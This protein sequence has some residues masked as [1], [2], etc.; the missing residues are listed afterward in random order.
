M[1]RYLSLV[2]VMF[3]L[4][5]SIGHAAG[6]EIIQISMNN[7]KIDVTQVPIIMDGKEV[8]TES[9]SFIHENRTLVPIRFVEKNY[10]AEVIWEGETRSVIV[11]YSDYS[12]KLTIDSPIATIYKEK[13][14]KKILDKGS[15]PRLVTFSDN[16]TRTMVPLSF[17]SEVLGFEVG[18]DAENKV[19]YI[20][21]KEKVE[22]D[23]EPE[24][25]V[26]PVDPGTQIKSGIISNIGVYKGSTDK[27]KIILESDKELHY[28]T[29]LI[30]ETLTFVIDVRQAKLSQKNTLDA[31]GLIGVDDDFIKEVRYSQFS[32]KP[33]I[34]RIAIDL[35]EKNIPNIMPRTDGTGLMI[36]FEN[37]SMESITKELIDDKEAIVLNGANG[38][39]MNIMKLRN[40]ERLVIDFLDTV[41]EGEPYASYPYD[42]GFIKGVRVSQF[43]ADNNYSSSD[44][45]VRVVLDIKDGV[46][47][48]NVKI[49]TQEDKVI[50]YPEKSFWEN[51]SYEKSGNERH[52]IIG[53]LINTK[54]NVDYD[55]VSKTLKVSLP[56]ENVELNDGL[57]IIQDELLDGIRVEKGKVETI[58][59][60]QFR[61]SIEYIKSSKD[62]DEKVHLVI[63]RNNDL[64][65]EDRLIV[66]D[67]G[68]GGRDPGARSVTGKYEKDFN[69][70]I[71][72]KLN[73]KLKALG[74]NTI[75]NRETDKFIDLYERARVANE[76]YADVFISIHANAHNNS[77][78]AGVQM[79]YCPAFNS[80]LKG[81]D[82]H[83]FAKAIMEGVLETTGAQD[84]GI[85]QRPR[86]VVLRETKM[87]AVL[88]EAGFLTNA[89]EEKLLFTEEYQNKVVDGIIKGV[90]NYFEID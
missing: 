18:W 43:K 25:P 16:V 46:E 65:P 12:V 85:I 15:I 32:Y 89:A 90:V 86:L 45:I 34:T 21:S 8:S 4:F 51:I 73:D 42:L 70:L 76:N 11:N 81:Q 44:Q 48:P 60:L 83:P 31:P 72:H 64:K 24:K 5:S 62:I 53:N 14:I 20:N 87:P 47:D 19:P 88:V 37:H 67:A 27:N 1:K 22:E 40:P 50:I 30:E 38:K 41:L 79:L 13:E 36:S 74:Y 57:I 29:R 54:Y 28:E 49:D 55:N 17:L 82:Q 52:F 80:E 26:K 35:K 68:H 58:L 61:K 3:L 56:T 69:L 66:I 7:N 10:D 2:L 39:K 77:S 23:I 84:R 75:M 6:H 78:I 71:S 59:S 33:E 63:R 9:P